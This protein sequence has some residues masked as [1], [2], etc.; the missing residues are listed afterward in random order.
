LSVAQTKEAPP[1]A[2]E[3]R[4]SGVP[5]TFLRFLVV[6]AIAFFVTE[7]ALFVAY[8]TPLL[9]FL[10]GH[11]TEWGLLGLEH[12]DIR[13]LLATM[14]AVETAIIFKYFAYETW[15]FR[16]RAR[17]A[18]PIGRFLQ[19][20][21]ASALGAGVTVLTVNILTPL[22]GVLP[23]IATVAGVLAAFMVNWLASAHIIWPEHKRAPEGGA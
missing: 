1:A 10:P 19:L 17:P 5:L 7:A 21:V 14:I 3:T 16:D 13:L 12:P 23:Y 18:G 8:D 15:A 22:L 4:D 6:G 9:W 20:N 2:K 11:D